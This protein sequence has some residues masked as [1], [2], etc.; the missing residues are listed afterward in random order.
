M[1]MAAYEKKIIYLGACSQFPR[2]SSQLS[3]GEPCVRPAWCQ[4]VAKGLHLGLLIAGK[5][6]KTG[7]VWADEIIPR[8]TTP[9]T[10]PRLFL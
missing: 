10:E 7:L 3:Q 1:T 6:S 8:N 9:P 4:A 2:V 5:E